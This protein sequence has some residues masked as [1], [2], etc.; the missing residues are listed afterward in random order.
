[1][2]PLGAVR[3]IVHA[4]IIVGCLFVGFRCLF[5]HDMR[6]EAWRSRIKHRVYI[7]QK[8]FKLVTLLLGFILVAIGFYVAY[9]RIIELIDRP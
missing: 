6:R 2:I 7:S 8:R 5:A 1:M 9:L 3:Y 4:T